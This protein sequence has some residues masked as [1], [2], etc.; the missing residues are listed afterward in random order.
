[1]V[2]KINQAR[3]V[4][5]VTARASRRNPYL[6]ADQH[7]KKSSRPTG[8]LNVTKVSVL[9]EDRINHSNFSNIRAITPLVLR[10]P[11]KTSCT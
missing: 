5:I 7:E 11:D 4:F 6:L 2:D 1:M 8:G 3:F 9:A 10:N